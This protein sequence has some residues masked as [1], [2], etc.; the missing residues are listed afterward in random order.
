MLRIENALSSGNAFIGH[1]KQV[2]TSAK[3]Y[4]NGKEIARSTHTRDSMGGFTGGFKGS[5]AVLERCANTLAN[6][7]TT[8][9]KGQ[10]A[11]QMSV[12][13]VAAPAPASAPAS[14]AQ[15]GDSQA[16]SVMK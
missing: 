2:T 12:P 16:P 3:L 13:A 6:D 14:A 10:L 5:C 15:G 4:A 8:W 9:L 1:R 7:I 11:K